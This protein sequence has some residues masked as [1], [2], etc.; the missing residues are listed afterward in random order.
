MSTYGTPGTGQPEDPYQPASSGSPSPGGYPPPPSNYPPPPANTG[1]PPPPSN[2]PPPP[3]T[4]GYP[5][6]APTP[7]YGPQPSGYPQPP[8]TPGQPA[9]GY[10]PPTPP[11]SEW[12]Q[13]P[14]SGAAAQSPYPGAPEPQSA[15]PAPQSGPP[16]QFGVPGAPYGTPGAPGAPPKKSGGA[17]VGIIIGIVAVLLLCVCGGVGGW[18][19][20]KNSSD[21][22]E[23][24]PVSAPT[25]DTAPTGDEEPTPK[26]SDDEEDP[27]DDIFSDGD[28][29][30][31]EG[32][33]DD[34]ELKKVP[35]GPNTYKVLSRIPFTTDDE[36]CTDDPVFGDPETDTT[37]V[38][39]SSMDFADYVLCLKKQ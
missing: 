14:T 29:V 38:H 36:R 11:A 1:Y 15:P 9:G 33:N 34:P 35:C 37:Y 7:G 16:A 24:P 17:K 3:A 8:T 20:Y 2:Y 10:P 39:D 31:N 22:E 25:P 5:P 32:T 28:C 21:S 13:P 6:A 19:I 18:L 26:P 12:G 27:T 30:I 23:K 4:P